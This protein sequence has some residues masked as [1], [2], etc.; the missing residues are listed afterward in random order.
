MNAVMRTDELVATLRKVLRRGQNIVVVGWMDKNHGRSSSITRK[1]AETRRVLFF[2][3]DLDI[4]PIN[5]G[6]VIFTKFNSHSNMARLNKSNRGDAQIMNHA[7]P[8]GRIKE[9]L[10]EACQDIIVVEQAD[11][12]VND[13]AFS[14]TGGGADPVVNQ[15]SESLTELET[16]FLGQFLLAINED[17]DR[18]LSKYKTMAILQEVFGNGVRMVKPFVLSG[19]L[20]GVMKEGDKKFGSYRLGSR[21]LEAVTTPAPTK[22]LREEVAPTSKSKFEPLKLELLEKE[23][24]LELEISEIRRKLSVLRELQELEKRA[25]KLKEEL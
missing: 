10:R 12:L 9:L 15:H 16:R 21:A 3:S 22:P 2:E 7:F 17:S 24:S 5:T 4:L 23:K 20:E 8:I 19:L 11:G 14:K 6:V 13:E 1:L 25:E 18:S